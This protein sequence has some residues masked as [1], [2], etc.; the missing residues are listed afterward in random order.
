MIGLGGLALSDGTMLV[1]DKQVCGFTDAEEEAAQM[2]DHIPKS[3][4]E[5]VIESGAKWAGKGNWEVVAVADQGLVTGQNPQSAGAMA[6][7]CVEELKK[8]RS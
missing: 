5:A 6:K 7:L 1:K 2:T 4:Q 3:T 8:R